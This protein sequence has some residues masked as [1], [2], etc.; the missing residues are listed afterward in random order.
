MLGDGGAM[1]RIL[2]PVQNASMHLG[3]QSLDAAIQ[4]FTSVLAARDL[5]LQQGAYFNLGNTHFRVGEQAKDLD[6][7]QESWETAIKAYEHAVALDKTDRD[8]LLAAG[9]G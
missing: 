2:T 7:M 3:M 4:H 6:G 1:S 5:K 8:V 9:E